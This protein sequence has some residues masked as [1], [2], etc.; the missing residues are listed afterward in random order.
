VIAS[1]QGFAFSTAIRGLPRSAQLSH[2]LARPAPPPA[3]RPD[4]AGV[5]QSACSGA[6]GL[7]RLQEKRLG[8]DRAPGSA[9]QQRRPER[10]WPSSSAAARPFEARV[11][12]Q[13][14]KG[15]ERAQGRPRWRPS[16]WL[17]VSA[18]AGIHPIGLAVGL[19]GVRCLASFGKRGHHRGSGWVLPSAALGGAQQV[20]GASSWPQLTRWALATGSPDGLIGGHHRS[21]RRGPGWPGRL[22]Y[23]IW[24][25]SCNS[26]PPLGCRIQSSRRLLAHRA[27]LRAPLA[28]QSSARPPRSGGGIAPVGAA[29]FH[30]LGM[31]DQAGRLAAASNRACAGRRRQKTAIWQPTRSDHSRW[32]RR[33][34]GQGCT[35]STARSASLRQ[36]GSPFSGRALAA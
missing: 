2:R 5:E 36:P 17:I 8:P 21:D 25:R 19:Q 20:S 32:Q 29:P 11:K 13:G 23:C 7:H 27:R 24:R 14:Q 33:T 4:L 1:R 31:G 18:P 15:P 30:T 10:C 16:R 28:K 12:R 35:G 6:R 3:P 22:G 26:G 9:H 34:R